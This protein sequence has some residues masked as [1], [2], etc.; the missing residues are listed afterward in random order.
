MKKKQ[1]ASQSAFFNIRIVAGLSVCLFGF[2]LSLF[3][4]G[5]LP[6]NSTAP[7]SV[8]PS[9]TGTIARI[10]LPQAQPGSQRPEVN[11]MIGPV[12]QDKD[13]RLLPY[14][15][16]NG[17]HEEGGRLTR[18]PFPR[19]AVKSAKSPKSTTLNF[20]ERIVQ[21]AL[22]QN[23]SSPLLSFDAIDS[24][25]SGCGC[26]PPDSEGDVGSKNYISSMNSSIMLFDKSGNPLAGPI[27]YNSFF[28][29]MGTSTPCGNN[30][31]DGDGIVFYDHIA[32]RWVVSDFAFPGGS[33]TGVG[34][35][36]QCIGVSKTSDPVAGGWYLYAVQVDPNNNTWFGDYPKFG[37]WPDAYY[38][39][40][41]LWVNGSTANETFQGVRVY[42]F[43]RNSMING[44]SANTVAFDILAANLGD[45]YSLVPA[46]VRAGSPP[47]VGQPEW[48]LDVNSS[49]TAGTVETQLFIRRFH[50]DFVTPSNSTFGANANHDP[51]GV[52][53][54]NGF[55]D[56]FTAASE[57]LCP[58]GTAT[59]SQFLDTL[60]DK[61]MWPMVYQNLNG[62]EYLYAD[63]TVAP[64]NNGTSNTGPTA[65]RWYQVDVTGNTIPATPTQQGDWT[66]GN[67][68][69]Y[70]WMPSINV[71]GSGNMAIGYSA[72]STALNPGIRYTGRTPSDPPNTLEAETVMWAGTGHQTST[73]DRWGD[74]SALFVDPNDNCTFWHTNEYYSVSGS[75]SW[76]NRAGLFKFATCTGSA[77][78]TPT[79]TPTATPI[80]TPTPSP[81]VPPTSTPVPVTTPTPS[82]TPPASAGNV[83]VV[84]TAGT[85]GPTGYPTLQGAFAA[86]NAG[87]HQGA[88]TV[89]LMNSTTET[90]SCALN[91]PVAPAS[92][93]S[94]LVLPNGTQTVS[95]AIAAG[96]PLIDLN[97]AKNVRI[98]GYNQLTLANTTVSATAGTSTIR[99][100]SSTAGAGGAQNNI[101]ANCSIQGSATGALGAATGNVLFQHD[102]RE[103]N[104]HCWQ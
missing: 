12:H 79:P 87:T 85:A 54:V 90:S 86:I 96:S 59:S 43:D 35:N 48:F 95:G 89:W 38:L 100:I 93:S 42:A 60:G 19:P 68:G 80:A 3:A 24:N 26:L 97:G 41:N 103:R 33:G 17:E 73:A 23:I 8:A 40:V 94:V 46:S 55:I 75:S 15:P 61:I 57:D 83:T 11:R 21:A 53:T 7:A 18:Y 44:G 10:G 64:S 67:D 36:Y 88:V 81:T 69:L 25:V 74:Y 101:V 5:V 1:S 9:N 39:S 30:L 63:Q 102:D 2:V 6:G 82:P 32:D 78:P 65:V 52:I 37:M 76:R 56:A 70:R 20:G 45:Q 98:D 72:S 91:A 104:Q 27:T 62:K 47:P 16:A 28:A 84:A 4:A 34:P 51:D 13:L 66:N 49:S 58:N 29:A 14:I 22:T 50:V 71:D 92:Y 31:N 77:I 99:F